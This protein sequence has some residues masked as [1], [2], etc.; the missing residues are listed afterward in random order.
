M[1]SFS[2]KGKKMKFSGVKIRDLMS[3][4][5]KVHPF[6]TGKTVDIS[7]ASL[8]DSINEYFA[9]GSEEEIKPGY[10]NDLY[11]S[12]Q[13]LLSKRRAMIEH[14]E[15]Y[16]YFILKK[17]ISLGDWIGTKK[18]GTQQ[19]ADHMLIP[20]DHKMIR[21]FACEVNTTSPYYRFGFKLFSRKENLFGDTAIARSTGGDELLVHVGK[22]SYSRKDKDPNQLFIAPYR[23]GLRETSDKYIDVFPKNEPY[24]FEFEIDKNSLILKINDHNVYN[25]H[26]NPEIRYRTALYVWGDGHDPDPCLEIKKIRIATQYS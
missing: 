9:L 17:S 18:V 19:M 16:L 20:L 21:S 2:Q 12:T 23:N 8:A 14:I 26:V 22:S 24:T 25:A 13:E 10:I 3:E 5:F 11:N 15:D 6:D 1:G 7:Y 4:Y